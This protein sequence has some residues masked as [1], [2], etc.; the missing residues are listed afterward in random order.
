MIASFK[1]KALKRFWEKGDGRKLPSQSLPRITLLLDRL[2]AAENLQDMNLP[3][4]K[5]H[6]LRGN[7]KGRYAVWVTGN[8]RITFVWDESDA[9]AVDYEDYHGK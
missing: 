6:P 9:V 4:F 1:S 3:G 7:K 5:F 2:D 8:W